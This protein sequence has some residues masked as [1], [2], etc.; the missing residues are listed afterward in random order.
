MLPPIFTE[1]AEHVKTAFYYFAAIA[2]VGAL[3]AFVLAHIYGK[4]SGERKVIYSVVSIA[5]LFLAAYV[6]ISTLSA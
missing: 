6:T 4:T 3:C 2:V 1:T 5:G